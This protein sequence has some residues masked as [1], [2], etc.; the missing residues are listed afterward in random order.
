ML[1]LER[2]HWQNDL[3][4]RKYWKLISAKNEFEKIVR[5]L[6]MNKFRNYSFKKNQIKVF[7]I[8]SIFK[9]LFIISFSWKIMKNQWENDIIFIKIFLN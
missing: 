1:S 4:K 3:L 7:I 9:H 6:R 5:K 2:K 8:S